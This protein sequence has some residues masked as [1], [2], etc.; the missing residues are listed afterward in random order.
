MSSTPLTAIPEC[1]LDQAAR[2]GV[3]AGQRSGWADAASP[4]FRVRARAATILLLDSGMGK[5]IN[6]IGQARGRKTV[7]EFAETTAI[8]QKRRAIVVACA[9]GSA[10]GMPAS[11]GI[12]EANAAGGGAQTA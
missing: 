8:L 10:F 11:P 2:P 6:D 3:S 1:W 7:A 4:L 9:R 5:T 12:A